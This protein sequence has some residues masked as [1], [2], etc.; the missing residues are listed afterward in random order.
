[1][2]EWY[3]TH[4]GPYY[5]CGSWFKR[6]TKGTKRQAQVPQPEIA[7]SRPC[8]RVGAGGCCAE[9]LEPV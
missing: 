7:L 9:P 2:V 4:P 8:L 3:N 5:L 1:M 6:R